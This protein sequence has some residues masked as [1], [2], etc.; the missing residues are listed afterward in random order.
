MMGRA[1]LTAAALKIHLAASF[2][3]YILGRL[4]LII[5]PNIDMNS[6]QSK[7]RPL[8]A[9]VFRIDYRFTDP[10]SVQ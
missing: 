8:L 10:G 4:G 2:N 7:D 6:I 9:L 1:F 5:T 3:E